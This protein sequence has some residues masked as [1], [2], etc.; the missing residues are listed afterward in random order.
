MQACLWVFCEGL[1]FIFCHGGCF[2]FERLLS[3][4]SVCAGCY[5]LDGVLCMFPVRWSQWVGLV[6]SS[7]DTCQGGADCFWFQGPGK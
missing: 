6:A 1:L 7:K 2:W 4:S 3:L 5:L